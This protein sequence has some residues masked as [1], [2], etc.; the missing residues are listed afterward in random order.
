M[1]GVDESLEFSVLDLLFDCGFR[2]E[3]SLDVGDLHDVI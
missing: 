1:F 2:V 3:F